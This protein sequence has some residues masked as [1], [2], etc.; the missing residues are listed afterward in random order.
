M[1][2]LRA[3]WVARRKTRLYVAV[4]GSPPSLASVPSSAITSSQSWCGTKH[5]IVFTSS[6]L[7]APPEKGGTGPIL[8]MG[9]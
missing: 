6:V 1:S 2:M 8:Q 9:K 7:T 3:Q 4:L 5:I